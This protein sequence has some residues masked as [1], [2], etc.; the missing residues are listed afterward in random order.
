MEQQLTVRGEM[1]AYG[2][3]NRTS[4]PP[5][6][7]NPERRLV[8]TLRPYCTTYVQGHVAVACTIRNTEIY[9]L[10][11]P[12]QKR[13]ESNGTRSNAGGTRGEE[14]SIEHEGRQSCH[15]SRE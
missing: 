13:V 3:G 1:P 11:S 7:S 12:E 10:G 2:L 6:L 15:I 4:G 8:G 5:N 14:E 9:A